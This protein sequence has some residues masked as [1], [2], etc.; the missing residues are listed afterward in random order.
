MTNVREDAI[1]KTSG[2][3][4][5]SALSIEAAK[6]L[7]L[8]HLG[9]ALFAIAKALADSNQRQWPNLYDEVL[10]EGENDGQLQ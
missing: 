8:L 5:G 6:A 2:Y 3:L 7:A 9:D 10:A 1:G 4:G